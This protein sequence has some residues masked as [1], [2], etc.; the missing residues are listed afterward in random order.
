MKTL[1]RY[2][3]AVLLACIIVAAGFTI[4]I[5]SN[6][7]PGERFTEFYILGPSGKATGYPTNLT[8]GETGTVILGIVNHEYETI[9]YRIV[10]RL[11][12]TSIAT[13]NDVVLEHEGGWESNYT[14]IPEVSCERMKLEFFLY[15]NGLNEIYRSLH[16]WVSV[17]S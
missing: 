5:A 15:K 1:D 11:E 9:T 7:P 16:L 4:Y 12:N 10:I 13:V 14:F 2:I 3:S 8:L 17:S 6:P